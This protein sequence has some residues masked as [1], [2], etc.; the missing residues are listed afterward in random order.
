MCPL[1]LQP[2]QLRYGRQG[3]D[4]GW[5]PGP[6]RE[7]KGACPR[8][9]PL[10]RRHPRDLH[11]GQCSAGPAAGFPPNAC[12]HAACGKGDLSSSSAALV[13]FFKQQFL[14]AQQRQHGGADDL[15][16]GAK[17]ALI[18]PAQ[19]D[20]G[21]LAGLAS[22]SLPQDTLDRAAAALTAPASDLGKRTHSI[23]DRKMMTEMAA[24]EYY[25]ANPAARSA[26]AHPDAFVLS[27][28]SIVRDVSLAAPT[29]S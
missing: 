19:A 7:G 9:L 16:H 23:L 12:A 11:A 6:G 24:L 22:A 4:P 26:L 27:E 21:N 17:S 29:S 3:G 14:T 1:H 8:R 13:K 10:R 15:Q 18:S 25:S 20:A 28:M 2:L 5:G